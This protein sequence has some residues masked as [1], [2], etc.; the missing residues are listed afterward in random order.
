MSGI[1]PRFL[2]CPVG[3]LEN[4]YLV[5]PR[6]IRGVRCVVRMGEINGYKTFLGKG[7]HHLEDL[8]VDERLILK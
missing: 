6:A 8:G 7:K 3:E 5:K 2:D 1:E 4:Q